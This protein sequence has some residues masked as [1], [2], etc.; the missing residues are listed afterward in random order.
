[1][2]LSV[3]EQLKLFFMNP[4]FLSC[5]C[6]WFCAQFMKTIISLCYGRIHRF[7]EL[8][9][10]MFWRTGSLPSSHSA[11]VSALCTAIAFHSGINSDVFVLS[12]CFFLVTIRDALGVRRANGIQA[13]KLNEIGKA[14]DSQRLIQYKSMKEVQGHT[15][16]EVFV[17]CLLGFSIG[18][19]FFVL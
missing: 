2:L 4:V 5:I 1:M 12:L 6:S 18:L 8:F 15:P 17:G 14:L 19:A 3:R 10:M 16:L 13:K 11:M 7:T 9:E